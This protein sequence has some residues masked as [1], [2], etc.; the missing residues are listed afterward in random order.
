MSVWFCIPSAR[1]PAE[2][3]KCLKAW[4]DRGYRVA[5]WRD[6]PEPVHADIRLTA[7]TYPGYAVAVNAL[8]RAVLAVDPSCDWVVTGGDDVFPDP[9][10]DPAEI[11][12]EC[13]QHFDGILGVMQPTG[14]RYMVDREGRCAAE[15]VCVSPWMGREWC[16]RA[17]QGQG[18]L[19]PPL[20]W[21]Y[22]DEDLHEVAKMHG[23][24]WH[25]PDIVQ[26]HQW[27]RFSGG[28]EPPHI[29]RNRHRS[30]EG[31]QIFEARKAAGFPNSGFA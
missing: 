2:A 3:N 26:R 18:P 6:T 24:L 23:R 27:W 31:R 9:D 10:K 15:R 5:V 12:E 16:L 13:S 28:Q 14:H 19:W 1:P 30:E 8:A 7:R 25:R 4:T 11:A 22:V 20:R 29:K 17:Y 21:E